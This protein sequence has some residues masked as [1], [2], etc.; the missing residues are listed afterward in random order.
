MFLYNDYY[1]SQSQIFF[2]SLVV[3]R[4]GGGSVWCG[5][6]RSITEQHNDPRPSLNTD[7]KD[8]DGLVQSL[9]IGVRRL[10]VRD[11]KGHQVQ[12][13]SGLHTDISTVASGMCCINVIG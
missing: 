2:I 1:I 3:Q 12:G 13:L 6:R 10:V 11:R 4:K 7:F 9:V 5:A 8:S